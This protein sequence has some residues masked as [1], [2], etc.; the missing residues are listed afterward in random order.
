M[1][2]LPWMLGV[3]FA[4]GAPEDKADLAIKR[5]VNFLLTQQDRE[6]AIARA[7]TNR[8]AMT[9][10]ALLALGSVGHQPGDD[11]PE[12]LCMKRALAFVVRPGSQDVDGYFGRADGSRM[13]GHGI[14]TLMLAEFAGMGADPEQDRLLADRCKS[15]LALI[16]RA[17]AIPKNPRDQGGW[18]YG[19]DS[20]DSDLSATVWQVSALRS[21]RNAGFEV[22][23]EAIDRAIE[24]IKR[25]YSSPRDPVGKPLR[26]DSACGYQTGHAPKFSTA[27]AGLLA[28]QVCGKY[29]G[30]EVTGA[31]DWLLKTKPEPGEPWFFY[32]IYYYAQGMYQRGGRHAEEAR[33]H[34]EE[35]L[36]RIQNS[37]GSWA[38]MHQRD[39]EGAAGMIYSSSLAILALAVKHHFLPIY[40]R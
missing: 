14:V 1:G 16:L 22:P 24:Y 32:G 26:L 40:Q 20:R 15:A 7:R 39:S 35:V 38:A 31:A 28:L 34:T 13:Y 27:G 36:T 3:F 21:A 37:D 25:C 2:I 10:L 9:A 8:T 5:G 33:K 29:E 4:L 30:P 17:Q 19:P 12:G 23:K 6:G 18:R 11:T